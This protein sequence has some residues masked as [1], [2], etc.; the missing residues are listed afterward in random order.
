MN[1]V[2]GKSWIVAEVK[3]CSKPINS[4]EF[5]FDKSEEAAI[6]FLLLNKDIV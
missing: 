2:S 3:F 4:F 6:Y 1:M 5:Y